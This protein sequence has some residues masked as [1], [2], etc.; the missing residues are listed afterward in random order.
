MTLSENFRANTTALEER[1]REIAAQEVDRANGIDQKAAGLLAAGLALM[2]AGVAFAATIGS[3]HVGKGARI[4]WAALLMLTLVLLLS[5]LVFAIAALR[6]RVFRIVL[7]IEEIEEWPTVG[8][9]DQDPTMVQ[10]TLLLGSIEATKE[11]RKVNK[12][13]GDRLVN[14]FRVFAAAVVAIVILAGAVAI[15]MTESDSHAAGREH[16]AGHISVVHTG[17]VRNGGRK[18]GGRR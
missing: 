1:A 14:A 16:A 13:K 5:S 2:A 8:Y 18:H 10:G 4:L 15:R 17:S 12:D 6:P 7:H 11:A 3:D 9:L